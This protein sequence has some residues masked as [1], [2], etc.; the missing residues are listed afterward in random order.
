MESVVFHNHTHTLGGFRLEVGDEH[1][2]V[3]TARTLSI[4]HYS[5]QVHYDPYVT[6]TPQPFYSLLLSYRSIHTSTISL[7][8]YVACASLFTNCT[9]E[10]NCINICLRGQVYPK[11]RTRLEGGRSNVYLCLEWEND[12]AISQQTACLVWEYDILCFK[13]GDDILQ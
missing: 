8:P 12:S 9:V 3:K 1:S 5:V 11:K 10:N 2:R 7:A 13:W 6:F 4:P